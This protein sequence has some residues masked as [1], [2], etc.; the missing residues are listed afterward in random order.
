MVQV[1]ID[2]VCDSHA[3]STWFGDVLGNELFDI[4]MHRMSPVAVDVWD[5]GVVRLIGADAD[6][7][8]IH[9]GQVTACAFHVS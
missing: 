4:P 6:C 8:I 1:S 7:T 3:K 2:V 5:V 9:L